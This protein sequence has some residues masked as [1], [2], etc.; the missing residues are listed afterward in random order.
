MKKYLNVLIILAA[1]GAVGS[2]IYF[3]VSVWS[4]Q[5]SD[6]GA[7]SNLYT[8]SMHPQVMQAGPGRCPICGMDLTPM[9]PH[10]HDD[11]TL[12][13]DD[14]G[15]AVEDSDAIDGGNHGS[16]PPAARVDP[17]VIQKMGVQT[18][19]VT[20]GEITKEIRAVA[21]IDFAEN[22]EAVVN[23]R[24]EGWVEKLYV[25]ITGASVRR[26]QALAGI[27]SPELVA[28]QEEYLQL[29]RSKQSLGS[30]PELERLLSAARRRLDTGTSAQDRSR[31][32]RNA[33]R[34][35]GC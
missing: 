6:A 22:A 1:A 9:K 15:D 4:G 16:A 35:R 7:S 17:A 34:R 14:E 12:H 2:G 5:Q 31:T 10:M 8:C 27:Y 24:F 18:E 26:G 11:G 19:I 21:H 30:S 25:N 13:G 3:G 28:T 32:W 23:A 20:R 33:A 29:F